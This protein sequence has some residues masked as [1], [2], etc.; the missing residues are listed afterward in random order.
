[1]A[2]GHFFL[3]VAAQKCEYVCQRKLQILGG[4]EEEGG[5]GGGA[6]GGGVGGRDLKSLISG[7]Q[8]PEAYLPPRRL[9]KKQTA[10]FNCH[11]MLN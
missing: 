3:A 2:S 5:G 1:M 7:I 4:G 10:S 8:P 9:Q 11:A 6:G